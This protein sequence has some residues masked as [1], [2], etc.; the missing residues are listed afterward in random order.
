MMRDL[1]VVECDYRAFFRALSCLFV[2]LFTAI[3]IVD[4]SALAALD[5]G[6]S[7]FYKGL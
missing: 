7:M 5:R 3:D 6:N 4:S 1:E 2:R